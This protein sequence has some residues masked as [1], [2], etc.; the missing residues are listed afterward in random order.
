MANE[1]MLPGLA[2]GTGSLQHC[3]QS[4]IGIFSLFRSHDGGIVI[5]DI[6]DEF[7]HIKL[8]VQMFVSVVYSYALY[9]DATVVTAEQ[10]EKYQFHF[11]C[12][13]A[14]YLFPV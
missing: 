7:G 2:L 11:G 1:L 5:Q 3:I 10:G 13:V 6:H 4:E 9:N 8:A 14:S 12:S